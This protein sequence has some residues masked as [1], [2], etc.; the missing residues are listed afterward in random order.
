M[1]H[2]FLALCSGFATVAVLS[3]ILTV[4]IAKLVPS[5]AEEPSSTT[6]TPA[7]ES[8][9]QRRSPGGIFVNLGASFLSAAAGGY[10]ASWVAQANP[11]I[12]VLA[13]GIIVLVLAALSALQSKG[14]QPVWYL[15]AQVVISPVGVLAGGLLRLR[16]QGIL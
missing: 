3:L 11:L 7:G 15:L 8:T 1:M 5:W 9:S 14:K 10:V 12:H 16:L 13:L 6:A 2:A 4:L